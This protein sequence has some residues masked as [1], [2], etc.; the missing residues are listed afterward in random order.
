LYNELKTFVWNHGKAAAMRGYTDDLV[1]ACAIGCWVRD[2]ALVAN[3]REME[4]KRVFA[5]CIGT[6]STNL[7]TRIK[8]ML[9]TRQR[10]QFGNAIVNRNSRPQSQQPALSKDLLWILKG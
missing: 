3:K 9:N 7:D 5:N 4:Y 10:D 2:T 6:N 8:G 1:M